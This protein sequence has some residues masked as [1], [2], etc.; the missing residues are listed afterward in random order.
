MPKT[1]FDDLPPS[2]PKAFRQAIKR[3]LA[4]AL[5][6]LANFSASIRNGWAPDWPPEATYEFFMAQLRAF[7]L[8]SKRKENAP[9][10]Q[11]M[12]QI[13]HTWRGLQVVK[14]VGRCVDQLESY[15]GNNL[16]G[17][18]VEKA[19]F[20]RQND[21]IRD[22][23]VLLVFKKKLADPEDLDLIRD[24]LPKSFQNLE[25]LA[26]NRFIQRATGAPSDSLQKV[27]IAVARSAQEYLFSEH[28]RVVEKSTAAK[29]LRQFIFGLRYRPYT[30]RLFGFTEAQITT[31]GKVDQLEATLRRQT[32][33]RQKK[34]VKK[35]CA[36]KRYARR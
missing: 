7:R 32:R 31:W 25:K 20:E 33:F 16:I 11:L 26:S 27:R 13:D 28:Q 12:R 5:R 10:I 29:R 2:D 14:T 17:S 4:K 34:R 3:N 24:L 1:P 23:L 18:A 35:K 19:Q 30:K 22:Q 15:I 6:S 21:P 36:K 9:A 8:I